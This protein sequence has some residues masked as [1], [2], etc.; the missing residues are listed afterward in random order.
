MQETV[1][2]AMR[3]SKCHNIF[4]KISSNKNW[5][6]TI[7]DDGKGIENTQQKGYQGNGLKN[8]KMRAAE[9][10]WNAEWFRL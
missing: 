7:I 9:A 1:N 3:H 4:I 10:G 8:I 6:I 2:N 5:Q